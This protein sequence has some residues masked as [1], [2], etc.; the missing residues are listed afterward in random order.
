MVNLR[1]NLGQ[2]GY[3]ERTYTNRFFVH[4]LIRQKWI[5]LYTYHRI[6]AESFY[7]VLFV[8]NYM[9]GPRRGGRLAVHL[10]FFRHAFLIC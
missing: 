10:L 1:S 7:F 2:G 3:W 4:I 9:G 8:C 6:P 5:D